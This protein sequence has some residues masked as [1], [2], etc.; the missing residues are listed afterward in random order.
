MWHAKALNGYA[1][2]STEAEDNCTEI[3]NILSA[4]GYGIYSICAI[5]GNIYKESGYN[6]WQWE[7]NAIKSTT[8]YHNYSRVGYG[9]VQWTPSYEYIDSS[10]AQSYA[11]YSPHFSDR[12]GSAYDGYSQTLF[13]DYQLFNGGNYFWNQS[14]YQY[15]NYPQD[16]DW[17]PPMSWPS[18][19]TPYFEYITGK[20]TDDF[21]GMTASDFKSGTGSVYDMADYCGAFNLKYLRPHWYYA[22]RDFN[23]SV[24]TANH[25]YQYFSGIP[26]VPPTP[27]GPIPPSAPHHMPVW[28]MIDYN[29]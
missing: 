14:R 20:S 5:L 2:N 21:T 18:T 11:G 1:T 25:W 28:M 22:A 19:N 6:P 4:Q 27:P 16:P 10:I 7:G 9:L 23:L 26:P 29:N 24:Q 13:V 12:T 17:N 8:N 15:Y 3:Y